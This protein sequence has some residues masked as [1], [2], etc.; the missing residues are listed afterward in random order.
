MR[1]ND[2]PSVIS[3][4]NALPFNLRSLLKREWPY[5]LMLVLAVVG[6]A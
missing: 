1:V 4:P 5:L 2:P 3:K 6:V